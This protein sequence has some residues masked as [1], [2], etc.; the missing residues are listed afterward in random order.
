MHR[1]NEVGEFIPF[2]NE[3]AETT[4]CAIVALA[5]LNKKTAEHPMFRI[6]G[7]IG[8]AASIRSACFLGTDPADRT[9]LALAHDKANGS[10]KG[11]TI[12]FEK[13][14]GSRDDPPILRAVGTSDATEADVCK[15]VHGA[16]GRPTSEA[17]E[18]RRFI[19]EFLDAEKPK[20]WSKVERVASARS[21][22]SRGTLN[23]VRA[24][25]AK[26]GEIIKIGN[27]RNAKWALPTQD[28]DDDE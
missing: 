7:S 16:V 17:D 24:E 3:I 22:A 15:I 26:A 2:L 11:Q 8:F 18:A 1:Q 20:E 5:H 27:A 12:V 14:G 13:V 19:F 6:V 23:N 9:R 4:G 28:K 10:E 25:M 21:I